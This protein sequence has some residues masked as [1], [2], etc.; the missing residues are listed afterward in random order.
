MRKIFLLALFAILFTSCGDQTWRKYDDPVMRAYL[1]D[2]LEVMDARSAD[3]LASAYMAEKYLGENT[4]IPGWEGFPVK[5][6]EYYTDVD[7]KINKP[8]KGLVYMFNPSPR[9]LS[10]WILNA[11]HAATDTLRYEDIK[12]LSNFI[13]WQSGAQFPVKGVVYE[14]MYVKNHFRPYVFKDGVTVYLAD[15]AHFPRV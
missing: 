8:K 3:V 15:A 1:K 5:L 7:V 6:Y 14:A 11:V 10:M 4:E 9:Q 2:S 13:K 12:R